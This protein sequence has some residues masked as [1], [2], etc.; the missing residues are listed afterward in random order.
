[1]PWRFGRRRSYQS[2]PLVRVPGERNI[3]WSGFH[4]YCTIDVIAAQL[5][6]ASLPDVEP[7]SP[8]HHAMNAFSQWRGEQFEAAILD[9]VRSDL[10][11]RARKV[12][13]L[14]EERLRRADGT[15][16]GDIDVLAAEPGSRTLLN[17][18]VVASAPARTPR[19]MADEI[20]R[21]S[22]TD[23]LGRSSD[24]AKSTDSDRVLERAELIEKKL[25]SA[26]AQL[27]VQSGVDGWRVQSLIVLQAPPFVG[28]LHDVAV[29]TLGYDELTQLDLCEWI[30]QQRN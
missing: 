14:D 12:D 30:A 26:L 27:G 16:L 23:E 10:R 4:T 13:K 18:E 21:F 8:L 22:T 17:I 20:R 19:E 7:R 1:M 6:H 2:R 9:V 29:P 5:I 24:K 15:D 3:I 11:F 25:G 28:K